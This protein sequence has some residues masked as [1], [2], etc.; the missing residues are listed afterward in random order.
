MKYF[1]SHMYKAQGQGNHSA[2]RLQHFLR[3][4]L[5]SRGARQVCPYAP[6]WRKEKKKRERELP[7]YKCGNKNN[8]VRRWISYCYT[9][10]LLFCPG[11]LLTRIVLPIGIR[12]LEVMHG[13]VHD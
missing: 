10:H 7:D 1:T 3:P 4:I 8:T 5:S 6:K 2:G 9:Y 13:L 11:T 12:A